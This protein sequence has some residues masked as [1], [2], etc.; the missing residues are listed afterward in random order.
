MYVQGIFP[1]KDALRFQFFPRARKKLKSRSLYNQC[2]SFYNN[3]NSFPF[4]SLPFLTSMSLSSE[5]E[6]PKPN[7]SDPMASLE[8]QLADLNIEVPADLKN[9]NDTMTKPAKVMSSPVRS[10]DKAAVNEVA[11]I[12]AIIAGIHTK[13]SCGLKIVKAF[14]EKF[15]ELELVDARARKGTSRGTHYDFEICVRAAGSSDEGEWRRVEHKGSKKFKP[16][17]NDDTPWKAGVQFH[18]G[19]C[20]KYSS[21]K[22]YAK[23]WYTMYIESET[24]KK[25][26]GI[27]AE[28]PSFDDWFAKDCKV[29]A[30]PKTPFGLELKQKV[31]ARHGARASLL[32]ERTAVIDALE[33]TEDVLST[34][35]SEVLPIANEALEQKDYWLTIHGDVDGDFHCAWYPKFTISAIETIHVTKKKDIMFEFCCEGG[36]VFNGILRW[37]K[38]A[39][40][41]C[42]RIDLK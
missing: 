11:D 40:F 33:F 21:A 39:G 23:I 3:N 4:L 9:H 2:S 41:S 1:K 34:M 38:G 10:K 6:L 8:K 14:A 12:K 37:G 32:K 15:P 18:N 30:D 36:F 7:D 22:M 20:E 26:F 5:S 31:R 24:L 35:K 19:G 27:E 16:I 42:L 25:E 29:Q 28:T 17:A 13:N